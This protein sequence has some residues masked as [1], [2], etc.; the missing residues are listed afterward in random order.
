MLRLL[1]SRIDALGGMVEAVEQG[2][3]QRE[4]HDAAFAYQQ[5]VES[6]KKKIVGVNVFHKLPE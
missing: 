1:S 3:P 6:G 5:A 4:V 2:F